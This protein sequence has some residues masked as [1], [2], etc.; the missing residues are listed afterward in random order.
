MFLKSGLTMNNWSIASKLTLHYTLLTF[1]IVF[2]VTA[3]LYCALIA[4]FIR[5]GEQF[6]EAEIHYIQTICEK[7]SVNSAALKQEIDWTSANIEEI[8]YHYYARISDGQDKL[9]DETTGMAVALKGA[10][11]PRVEAGKKL[12]ESKRFQSQ[13]HNGYLLMSG[14]VNLSD[15][16][17]RELLVEIALDIT[18]Q[19]RDLAAYRYV[20][21]IVLFLGTLIALISG[22]FMGRQSMRC[23]NDMIETTKKIGVAQLHQR[24]EASDWPK[25]LASLASAFN[26]MLIDIENSFTRLS[27][28]SADLAHELRT[29][30]GNLMGEAEITL[31]QPRTADEYQRVIASSLE[32]YQRLSQM[33]DSLLFLARAENP[34]QQIRCVP[35]DARQVLETIFEYFSTLAE[36]KSIQLICEGE[37]IVYAD[38]VL[39]R[40]AITNLVANAIRHTPKGG[41][42]I[43]LAK[44]DHHQTE[45]SVTDN[46]IGIPEEHFPHIFDRFYRIDPA[47]TQKSG[48]TGL[49]LAIVKSI[50][51][52][53]HGEITL[54]SQPQQTV[55]TL[56]FP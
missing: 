32:E 31:Y 16:Q 10:V 41:H 39:L 52:L 29:P 50:M 45:I 4:V 54:K 46:G 8:A 5:A 47:R 24:L 15:G 20:A 34:Q 6:L 25:E 11:F 48:G 37:G 14:K 36:E 17:P 2:C 28:F 1:G 18:S 49:G 35:H 7:Q 9:I 38:L 23:I 12:S 56:I 42:I 55:F 40:R 27:Q 3:V 30:I 44:Q 26:E 19:Q 33:I 22:M 13:F 43:L 51:E 53:H 21:G